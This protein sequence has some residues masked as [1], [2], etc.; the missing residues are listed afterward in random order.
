[1]GEKNQRTQKDSGEISSGDLRRGGPCG[2][3]GVDISATRDEGYVT[4][5]HGAGKSSAGDLFASSLFGKSKPLPQ[6]AGA[7]STLSVKKYGLSL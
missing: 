2:A 1:M 7:L 4:G 6:I 5:V 3:I